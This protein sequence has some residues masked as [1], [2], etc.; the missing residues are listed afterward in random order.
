MFPGAN[1]GDAKKVEATP[2]AP[3][4]R[5]RKKAVTADAVQ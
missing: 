3:K 1:T 2:S 5:T 4:V